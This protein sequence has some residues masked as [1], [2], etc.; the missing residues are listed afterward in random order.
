MGRAKKIIQQ[1]PFYSEVIHFLIF[2]TFL[3]KS[4]GSERKKNSNEKKQNLKSEEKK[5][6]FNQIL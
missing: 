3:F 4:M 2:V 1:I 5:I 6:K